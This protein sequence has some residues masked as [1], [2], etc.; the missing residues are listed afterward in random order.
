[1]QKRRLLLASTSKIH[2]Q[3]Y[4]AYLQTELPDFFQG[5][6]TITFIPFARPGG[7][8]F[9]EYTTVA[10]AGFAGTGIKVMGIHEGDIAE[11]I[12][13]AEAVFTGG[14][15][16]FLLVKTL[17][18]SGLM[19]PLRQRILNGMPYMGSSAGTNLAGIS[20]GTTND[21]PIVWPPSLKALEVIDF[22][23]NPH[24]LDPDPNSKHMGETRETRIREFHKF[25]TQ[26]VV[27]LR[28]GS[29]LRIEGEDIF[30]KGEHHAR[31][32][33]QGQKP[34]EVPPGKLIW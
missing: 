28:E 17:H 24:Y 14:G 23:I 3:D 9:D 19:Q 7:I 8:T 20:V 26:D 15:N 25:N 27:G 13:N 32:F 18:E 31:C 34:V 2:G 29:W 4:M 21:M 11:N 6:K 33:R 12:E 5:I 1:M 22:N 10:K 30:L 16:T